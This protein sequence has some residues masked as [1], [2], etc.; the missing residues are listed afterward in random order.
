MKNL[1]NIEFSTPEGFYEVLSEVI[2]WDSESVINLIDELDT[3]FQTANF[4]VNA[5]DDDLTLNIFFEKDWKKILISSFHQFKEILKKLLIA[6]KEIDEE[7]VNSKLDLLIGSLLDTESLDEVVERIV[8]AWKE[9]IKVILRIER[10]KA[11]WEELIAK[12]GEDV[13]IQAERYFKKG[14]PSLPDHSFSS[15]RDV[16]Y[17]II[18]EW[19]ELSADAFLSGY[20]HFEKDSEVYLFATKVHDDSK[21]GKI[22]DFVEFIEKDELKKELGMMTLHFGWIIDFLMD[23]PK[24]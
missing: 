11:L 5:N 8:E 16:L 6:E 12:Y 19:E 1:E 22:I 7:S 10:V 15:S 4:G 9:E 18:K 17:A 23:L 24:K 20:D 14:N 13:I 2:W 21:A 3:Y